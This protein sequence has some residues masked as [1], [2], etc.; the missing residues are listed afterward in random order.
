[1]PKRSAESVKPFLQQ[2]I[3]TSGDIDRALSARK[4]RRVL[5]EGGPSLFGQLIEDNAVDE[6][7]IT[8]SPQ[9]V[10]SKVG[11]ISL[12]P[13]AM[14]TAMRPAHILG[15]TDGT[16]LTRWVRQQPRR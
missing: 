13:N 12:S 14:P 16:I 3:V 1:M 2:A 9:L 8:T 15:D 11:R 7:C 10:G 4:L 6:L 5:C